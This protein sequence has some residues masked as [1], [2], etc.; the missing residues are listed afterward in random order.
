MDEFGAEAKTAFV[1]EGFSM[2]GSHIPVVRDLVIDKPFLLWI[3][4][5]NVPFPLFAGWF[6]YGEW[7]DPKDN[8]E[9]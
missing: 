1:A 5:K 4:R 2:G 7:K 9:S 8:K 3:E 6:N